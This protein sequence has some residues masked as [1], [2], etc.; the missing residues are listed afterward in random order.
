MR[1]ARLCTLLILMLSLIVLT[2]S[3]FASSQPVG[4]SN[5][6]LSAQATG[7]FQVTNATGT[8]AQPGNATSMN[9]GNANFTSSS[10]SNSTTPAANAVTPSPSQ[11]K[12]NVTAE[13]ASLQYQEMSVTE[14]LDAMSSAGNSLSQSVSA[15]QTISIFSDLRHS[16]S[17]RCFQTG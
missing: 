12:M 4:S 16:R 9:S 5:L 14:E 10:S 11:T 13:V 3:T 1:P 2:Q 7:P 8:T 6:R 15:N 17:H